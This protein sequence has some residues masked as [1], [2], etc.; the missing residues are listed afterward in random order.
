MKI[1]NILS[2]VLAVIL[3]VGCVCISA[4]AESGTATISLLGEKQAIVGEE[5]EV[6]LNVEESSEDLVGGVYARITYDTKNFKLS[7]IEIS[8]E[9]AAAN[10]IDDDKA[11]DM[12]N[13]TVSGQITVAILDTPND[14]NANDWLTFVFTV[15]GDTGT[16]T[17]KIANAKVSDAI[18]V[19]LITNNLSVDVTENI[20]AHMIDV[21]GASIRKDGVGNIR[22]E[23]EIDA[24]VDRSKIEEIGFL[25]IPAACLKGDLYNGDL[26]FTDSGKYT[27]ADGR[28]VS[29]AS[30]C[31]KI[32]D[33]DESESK[34]YCYLTNTTTFKLS[35]AFAARAYVKVKND[36]DTYTYVY[37]DNQTY[38]AESNSYEKNIKGG[39]SSKSCIETAKAIIEKYNVTEL[40]EYLTADTEA[41]TTNYSDIVKKLAEY[42]NSF[43]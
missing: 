6:S 25:M 38:V 12:I 16:S 14:S 7:R 4:S 19:D 40:N 30:G 22:F 5:Y 41:W 3:L 23:A 15:Q 27:T 1:K 13:T 32:S 33:I 2:V 18:G 28:T 17:F 29:I 31:K 8:P 39:T 34:V 36:D 43:N 26:T 10:S 9:F 21:N 11:T 24:T 37:S 35:T 20:Y 42:E